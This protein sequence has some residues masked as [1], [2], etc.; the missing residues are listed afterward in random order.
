MHNPTVAFPQL[1]CYGFSLHSNLLRRDGH[2]ERKV[3]VAMVHL[4]VSP[5]QVE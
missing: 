4:A 1:N 3:M 2:A 5:F